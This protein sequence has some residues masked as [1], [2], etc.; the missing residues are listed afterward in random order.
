MPSR[1]RWLHAEPDLITTSVNRNLLQPTKKSEVK[2]KSNIKEAVED[3]QNKGK[4]KDSASSSSGE[5]GRAPALKGLLRH[6]SSASSSAK[7]DRSQLVDI[8][9][10]DTVAEDTERVRARKEGSAG[11]NEVEPKRFM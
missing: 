4:H 8:I 11:W 2:R 9:V 6:H 10:E 7:S 5:E 1:D 3:I